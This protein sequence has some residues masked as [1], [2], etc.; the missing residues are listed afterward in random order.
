MFVLI[1][2]SA[3]LD[4]SYLY[5]NLTAVQPAWVAKMPFYF[6]TELCTMELVVDVL[7][8]FYICLNGGADL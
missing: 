4:T 3:A 7:R 5:A 8:T 6:L 2:L 1:H